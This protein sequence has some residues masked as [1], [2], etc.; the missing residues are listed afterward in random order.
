MQLMPLDDS[1]WASYWGGYN[2][3]PYNVVPLIHRLNTEGHQDASGKL[4]GM[5]FIIKAM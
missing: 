4:F 1:R 2:R 3:V 5:N